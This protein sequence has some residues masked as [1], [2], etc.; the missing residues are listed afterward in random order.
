MSDELRTA[1]EERVIKYQLDSDVKDAIINLLLYTFSNTM[2]IK[3]FFLDK[4]YTEV[5]DGKVGEGQPAN[6]E[7]SIKNIIDSSV[8]YA[9]I[10]FRL[11]P[12]E[13]VP[14]KKIEH[15]TE[16]VV[17]RF[18]KSKIGGGDLRK[19]KFNDFIKALRKGYDRAVILRVVKKRVLYNLEKRVELCSL[20]EYMT[21]TGRTYFEEDE[22]ER[23]QDALNFRLNKLKNYTFDYF[24][25]NF[26]LQKMDIIPMSDKYDAVRYSYPEPIIKDFKNLLLQIYS[27]EQEEKDIQEDAKNIIHK[28]FSRIETLQKSIDK[29]KKN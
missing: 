17:Y 13:D 10:I 4:L 29:L 12:F 11:H 5:N 15:D 21:F 19:E 20:L 18:L 2:D 9:Y 8:E 26:F 3:S 27:S 22:L 25:M 23:L 7:E 14:M 24:I 16:E 6:V 28:Q 1:V